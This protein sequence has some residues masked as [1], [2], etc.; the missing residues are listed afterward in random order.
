M[1]NE[2]KKEVNRAQTENGA[3]TYR[4]TQSDCLDLF[5]AIGALRRASEKEVIERFA[6]AYAEDP[7]LAMRILFYAR[8]VRGGL[9]ERRVFRTCLRWLAEYAPDSVRR[10]IARIAEYGRWD[11][12]F[13]LEGTLCESCMMYLIRRQMHA[14]LEALEA[15][16]NVS[17][18]GKWMPSVNASCAETVR[19]AKHFARRLVMTEPEYRRALVKLRERIRIIENNLRERDYTFDYAAQPSKALF[20]YRA[21]FNRNDGERYQTYL[22]RVSHGEEKMHT[23][24]LAPYEMIAPILDNRNL[25][26]AERTSLDVTWNAQ[27]NFVDAEHALAI[28]DGSGSMYWS[29]N[30]SPASVALS[31][32]VY[33]AERNKGAFANHFITFSRNPQLIE[34]KGADIAEKIRYCMT[35]QEC[36]NTDIQKVFELIL[37]A[38][39]KHHVPQEK[40]PSAL[41]FITDMEFDCCSSAGTTNFEYAKRLFAQHGYSLPKVVFWNVEARNRQQPVTQNEQGVVLVSGCTPRIFDMLKNGELNPYAFMMQVLG[42]ERYRDI[43]A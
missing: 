30:P 2:L 37:S 11:D 3:A 29:Q 4:T 21:A 42:S 25:S 39:V 7:D 34:V 18:L 26:D 5:A 6:C 41:Y 38:A 24:T 13:V 14:D 27:E 32:G 20:K 12:L 17:L 19:R 35:Y 40:M 1:L 22:E 33:F 8:D 43:A 10:N 36:S 31:L 28:V 16:G 15:N 9:G 23:G